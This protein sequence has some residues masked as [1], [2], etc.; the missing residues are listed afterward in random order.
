MNVRQVVS[1]GVMIFFLWGTF[2]LPVTAFQKPK[3]YTN[4]ECSFSVEY[5][6]EPPIIKSK[7]FD[8]FM[9]E[10]LVQTTF[11]FN[12]ENNTSLGVLH[13]SLGL[14]G[15]NWKNYTPQEQKGI[16]EALAVFFEKPFLSS[17]EKG[18]GKVLGKEAQFEKNGF[19]VKEYWVSYNTKRTAVFRFYLATS[20]VYCVIVG[21]QTAFKAESVK[22]HR[23]LDSFEII[24]HPSHKAEP[25]FIKPDLESDRN[26]GA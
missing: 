10:K 19:P 4:E 8:P 13:L 14:I 24:P 23:F 20:G 2:H 6:G 3:R 26:K 16:R 17:I 15:K 25:L 5:D 22:A 9:N 11:N 18:G 21:Y 1:A 7:E 12:A